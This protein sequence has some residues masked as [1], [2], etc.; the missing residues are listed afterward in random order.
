[1]PTAQPL[2]IQQS[3]YTTTNPASGSDIHHGAPVDFQVILN[4]VVIV[5]GILTLGVAII[6]LSMT[7]KHRG[8]SMRAN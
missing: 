3:S 2:D 7:Y 5:V 1:M 8:G 4:I 6:Q